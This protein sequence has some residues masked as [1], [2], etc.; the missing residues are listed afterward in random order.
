MG[1][2]GQGF[3]GKARLI[4]MNQNLYTLLASGFGKPSDCAIEVVQSAGKSLFYTWADID[5]ASA[6]LANHLKS[7]KLK[8]NARVAVHVDKSVESLLLYLACLRSG[9][10]YLPLNNSYQAA[11]VDY[12][13]GNAKPQLVVCAP[14]SHTWMSPIA[15]KHGVQKLYTLGDQ[16]DGTLLEA[17]AGLPSKCVA[18]KKSAADMA[19][20]LYTSGTTGRSKGAMLSHGNLASN[21]MTLKTLWR[22]RKGDVLLHA[23]PIFH[24]HGLFVASHGALL[25][26]SKMIWL[27][28]F[29]A[30][31]LSRE[32]PRASVMM[33]VPT[34]YV[35]MLETPAFNAQA[36]A[37]VRLFISGS[38]P[39]LPDTFVKFEQLTGHKILERYG[40]SET[41]ML[42]S[43][44]YDGHRSAGTV[45]QPLPG[46]LVRLVD[47]QGQVIS[48]A[49][50]GSIGAIQVK[51]PN[52][53]S[54]YWQMPEKT[55]EEFTEDGF[56]KTGDMG[57]W[58]ANGYLSIV[59]RNKDLII[60]GG[61]NVYPKEIESYLDAQPEVFESAVVGIAHKDFGEAVAAA[62]VLKPQATVTAAALINR[63]KGL[64]AGFK[65][66]K[67]ILLVPELPRNSMG[68]VQKNLIR[69]QLVT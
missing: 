39:L 69:D 23:L 44:S 51:G 8:A 46:V 18:A 65:V 24:V 26:G 16:R 42:T 61:Y 62:V 20:I 31:A 49:S 22:W 6:K 30:A 43:N 1:Q 19:A 41:V 33:G 4:S 48:P 58:D 3:R 60:T 32:L 7:H 14:G 47:D 67:V 17:A 5:Q 11:E 40:M 12:F 10:V 38:A 36:A 29:E 34:M 57:K 35:R 52:V 15:K 28:K 37:N 25:N 13:I 68:K 2:G 27:N 9:A 56:F 53:F 59:G 64:I 66:P 54:G 21:A 55:A 45:G 50:T 63:L